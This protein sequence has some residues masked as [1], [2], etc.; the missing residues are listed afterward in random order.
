MRVAIEYVKRELAFVSVGFVALL[1]SGCGAKDEGPTLVP[2]SGTITVDGAPIARAGISFRPDES[3]GNTVPYQPAGS[4]DENGKYELVTAAKK[5]AP[6][7][8]YKVVV[9]PYSPPPGGEA[10]PVPPPSFDA[11][12]SDPETTDLMFEIKEGEQSVTIDLKLTK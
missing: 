12:Y 4:A 2:V 10:P 8:W 11:K 3:K 1:I 6:P 9:F 5:G 7:G